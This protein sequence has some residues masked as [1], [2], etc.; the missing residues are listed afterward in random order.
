MSTPNNILTRGQ[1]SAIQSRSQ[2]AKNSLEKSSSSSSPCTPSTGDP[3]AISAMFEKLRAALSKK[4]DDANLKTSGL[5][6]GLQQKMEQS[7][8]A[9]TNSIDDKIKSMEDKINL[10]ADDFTNLSTVVTS[11]MTSL[12]KDISVKLDQLER[13]E[14]LLDVIVKNIPKV[15][16][17][18]TSVIFDNICRAIGMQETPPVL[19]V[20]RMRITNRDSPPIVI[21]FLDMNHKS[22]FLRAYMQNQSLSTEHIGFRTNTRVYVNESLS[23]KNSLIFTKALNL[24]KRGLILSVAS[25][26]GLVF[27]RLPNCSGSSFVS[28]IDTLILIETEN[29]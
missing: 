16:S 25:R 29:T 28:D 8:L 15:D 4:I 2:V 12:E 10:V 3:D 17:E 11:K 24:K 21:K 1:K 22:G 18:N 9:L 26:S 13:R 14:K 23:R 6:N 19:S 27:V 20:Y 7:Y 5:I